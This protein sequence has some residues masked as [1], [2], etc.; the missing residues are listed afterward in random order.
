[1]L[2]YEVQYKCYLSALYPGL[3]I[4][5]YRYRRSGKVFWEEKG[6]V[7]ID[8]FAAGHWMG[9]YY[10]DDLSR[11][12]MYD[13]VRIMREILDEEYNGNLGEYVRSMVEFWIMNDS[14][15]EEET[16]DIREISLSFVTDGWER[17]TV[18]LNR[19]EYSDEKL[20]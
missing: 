17:T 4:I 14:A 18:R 19:K 7:P 5:R 12:G 15:V 8:H 13:R 6:E 2:T 3:P 11:M 1:M 16:H 9:A 20:D 10:D